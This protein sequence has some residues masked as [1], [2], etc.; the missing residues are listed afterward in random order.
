VAAAPARSTTSRRQANGL[1]F[2]TWAQE[3]VHRAGFP[4]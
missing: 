1:T 2:R 4:L 3:M